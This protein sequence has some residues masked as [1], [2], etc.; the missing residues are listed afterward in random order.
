MRFVFIP[1]VAS[2]VFAFPSL[3]PKRHDWC[4]SCHGNLQPVQQRMSTQLPEY[5]SM[6]WD[7][8]E[9]PSAQRPPFIEIP[10]PGSVIHGKTYYDWS[11]QSITEIYQER[12]ID[13]F[14]EGRDFPCQ[15]LSVKE[16][17]YLISF[18]KNQ[19]A[20]SCCQWSEGGFY[21]PRPDVLS[22]M[23][24]DDALLGSGIEWLILDIELPGPFGYGLQEESRAPAAF[25]F[26]VRSGWVQQ[27]FH[28]FTSEQPLPEV[29][30]IPAL[31]QKQNLKL[32]G[33]AK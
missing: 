15:F 19:Q 33:Q 23:K 31:C 8:H 10:Q 22:I 9:F 21:A 4:L 6:R 7:M 12:C 13:I 14:P 20:E 24:K 27:N 25:W 17:T 29:F 26:P 3:S 16:K 18:S 30:E 2:V 32:C 28:G 5:Y 1:M 11:R